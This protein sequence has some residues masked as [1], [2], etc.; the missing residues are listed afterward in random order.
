MH[1]YAVFSGIA[2][3]DVLATDRGQSPQLSKLP[4]LIYSGQQRSLEIP[5][6]SRDCAR[7]D[8]DGM[9]L[10]ETVEVG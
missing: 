3:C 9:R 6:G 7:W 1:F 2:R 5:V 10:Q 8:E 4:C